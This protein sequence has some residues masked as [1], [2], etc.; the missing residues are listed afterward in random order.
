MPPTLS[1]P[2][3][4]LAGVGPGIAAR[5][6][7]LGV[8]TVQDLLF[9]LPHRYIDRTR[10]TPL[11]GL[12]PGQEAYVQGSIDLVQVKYGRRRSLLCRL[13]DG[14]GT[15]VLRFFHFSRYQ[16]ES[17]QK[18]AF[19]RCW[20]QARRG[21]GGL[22]MIHPE[23]RKIAAAERDRVEQTLTP[24]YPATEGIT[25]ARLRLCTDQALKA[26]DREAGAL[27]ELLPPELLNRSLPSL[28]EALEY[29]HR[30]PPDADV[31]ALLQGNHSAQRRLVVEELLAHQLSY[32][33][34]REKVKSLPAAS[35]RKA[36]N[37][38]SRAFVKALPFALTRAQKKVLGEINADLD[39]DVPMLRLIQGDVGSGKTVI[40]ALAALRAVSAGYQVA[41]MAPTE[42]LA[43]QHYDNLRQWLDGL[44][45]EVVLLTGR[46]SAA[47]RST[48]VDRIASGHPLIAV[49]TH[50]LF[51]EGV[52][53]GKLGL[54]V[55]DEQHR[56]G[57]HQRLALLDKGG[58]ERVPHQLIM[59]A[60]P[61]PRTLA[62][63]LFAELDVS[64]IDELPPGR[65]PVTTVVLSNQRRDEIVER[66]SAV[67]REGHQVYWICTLIEESEALQCQ[68]AGKTTELLTEALPHL[69]VGL[70]HGRLNRGEKERVMQ[71]FKR[72]D[73][74]LLVAT[75]VIEVGVDVPNASLMIIEN[76][77]RMGLAQLH[78]LRGRVG[79]GAAKSVCVLLYQPPMAELARERL[80]VM[81]S[82]NDGFMLA[83]KDLALRG[84]GDLLGTRQTGLPQ[85]R[86][87]DLARDGRYLPSLR[88]VADRILKDYPD[89]ADKLTSRWLSSRMEYG[90]V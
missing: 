58:G 68:A 87:A 84:P 2:V 89:L 55:I 90:N 49:G 86:I 21:A 31:Q 15:I 56:F 45:A 52:S 62:M 54:A 76:A 39:R 38:L 82:C 11:G 48:A 43:E 78:Q 36:G 30:P 57:V 69:S 66:I 16:Q 4:T 46:L 53:F 28:R 29:L 7:H 65:Q 8:T 64:V 27:E 22:E 61:I 40:A 10:L 73:I 75:T 60:T 9:H 72:G 63:T 59:T 24:V 3:T 6:R 35:F 44:E 13:S 83:E 19:L 18:G 85:M 47:S 5:L 50:A 12:M 32:R 1:A 70:I 26:L 37:Y 20:G 41:L 71:A 74:D 77:E 88:K 33:R 42:I 25:Q 79:R 80:E 34:L 14:T 51:Q 81:R 17:L 23:Y 67:C